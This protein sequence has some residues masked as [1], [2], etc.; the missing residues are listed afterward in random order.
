MLLNNDDNDL[1]LLESLSELVFE[2][3]QEILR[4]SKVVCRKIEPLD[5]DAFFRCIFALYPSGKDAPTGKYVFEMVQGFSAFVEFLTLVNVFYLLFLQK[6][7]TLKYPEEVQVPTIPNILGHRRDYFKTKIIQPDQEYDGQRAD[8]TCS[9]LMFV[10][11]IFKT[12]KSVEFYHGMK[13][14]LKSKILEV[15]EIGHR[16]ML[17]CKIPERALSLAVPTY[18]ELFQEDAIDLEKFIMENP[19]V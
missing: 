17:L 8:I 11:G 19:F 16:P 1:K 3:S 18:A 13:I 6:N 10:T 5:T 2:R 7:A 4:K 15:L 14:P 9:S 12:S